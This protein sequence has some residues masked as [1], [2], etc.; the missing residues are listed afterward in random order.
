MGVDYF[1]SLFPLVIKEGQDTLGDTYTQALSTAPSCGEDER[2]VFQP[3]EW[4]E[5]HTV[6]GYHHHLLYIPAFLT[7]YSP[8]SLQNKSNSC[9]RLVGVFWGQRFITQGK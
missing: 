3:G 6:T 8:Q 1:F 4:A 5:Q 7:T 9:S 2:V